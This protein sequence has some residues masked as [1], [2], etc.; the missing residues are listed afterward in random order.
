M[1]SIQMIARLEDEV[2]YLRDELRR[3]RE[4]RT[5][6][7]RRRDILFSQFSDQLKALAQTTTDVQTQ[8]EA[9]VHEVVSEPASVIEE[10]QPPV[11]WWRRVFLGES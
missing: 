11:S 5:E 1:G 3:E 2:T 8:V 9:V 4:A 10:E 6:A 7:D